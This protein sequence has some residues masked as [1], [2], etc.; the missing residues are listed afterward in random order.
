MSFCDKNMPNWMP[1]NSPTGLATGAVKV[2]ESA[3]R[4]SG[5]II[6]GSQSAHRGVLYGSDRGCRG[7]PE[8][9]FRV[10]RV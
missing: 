4:G 6:R 2:I 1:V 8:K 3:S 5:I 9:C 7:N 10:Q